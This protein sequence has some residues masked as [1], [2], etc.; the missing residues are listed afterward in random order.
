[1]VLIV[2]KAALE[3]VLENMEMVLVEKV[4]DMEVV[5]VKELMVEDMLEVKREMMVKVLVIGGGGVDDVGGRC[6]VDVSEGG[7]GVGRECVGVGG[8]S[9]GGGVGEGDVGIGGV[10]K[11]CAGE[12]LVVEVLVEDLLDKVGEEVLV[13]EVNPLT[14]FGQDR[15]I[16]Y[17]R[18]A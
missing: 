8:V 11:G 7:A 9:K 5:L 15:G 6:V 17:I 14:V 1:M 16:F 13:Q 3:A 10:G 12:E 4:D 18:S 2:F